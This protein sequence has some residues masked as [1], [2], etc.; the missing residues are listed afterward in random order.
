VTEARVGSGTL[1]E[2]VRYELWYQARGPTTWLFLG[3]LTALAFLIA[4]LQIG[5]A[6]AATR[7]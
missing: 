7:R 5:D 1:R 6:A 2:I 3:A 4:H